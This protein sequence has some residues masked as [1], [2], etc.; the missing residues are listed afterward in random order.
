M[1][2]SELLKEIPRET[3]QELLEKSDLRGALSLV[4][5]YALLFLS[6][7]LIYFYPYPLAWF[8][9]LIILAN[10]QLGLAI[11][12]HDAAHG[13]LFKT[14][15]LNTILGRWL[16]AAPVLA[17][18]DRYRTYH[19]EHHRTA[20]TAQDPDRSNYEAYPVHQKS[21]FRKVIRDMTGVTGLKI[22]II[23]I[24]MNAGL[25]KYQLSYDKTKKSTKPTLLKQLSG[26]IRGLYPTVIFHALI[27]SL[28]ILIKRPEIYLSW[29]LAWFTFYMLFS[30]I[31]NAAEHGATKDINT[32][33]PLLNTRTTQANVLE[34]LTVAPHF[35]NYH[36]EHH[37]LATVPPH[38]LKKFHQLL[39][40]KNLLQ[41][42]SLSSG[43]WSV[44]R[45]L[46]H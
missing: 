19:L 17:D 5:G 22:F 3:L 31:R 33:N 42:S 24:K 40:S 41:Q 32:D 45:E 9:T 20:G 4:T 6:F 43:Y 8:I 39:K 44:L 29:W 16:C 2:V 26:L 14:P 13:T 21:F 46:V 23:V 25:V 11:L 10:R 35:V 27:L 38:K 18:L 28:F 34:R 1:K 15:V 36:L 37:I 7:A 30:R 12:M